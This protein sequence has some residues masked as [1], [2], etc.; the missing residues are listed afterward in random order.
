MWKQAAEELTDENSNSSSICTS[1]ENAHYFVE[2][3]DS[4]K[5]TYQERITILVKENTEL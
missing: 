3:L 4:Y 2:K 5:A 1:K